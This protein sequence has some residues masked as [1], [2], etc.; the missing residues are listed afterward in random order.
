MHHTD[1]VDRAY[2]ILGLRPGCSSS[3][4]KRRYKHLVKTWHPDRWG[5]DPTGQTE[6]AQRLREINLA[7]QTLTESARA[8]AAHQVTPVPPVPESGS[9]TTPLGR[10]LTK[11]EVEAIVH[12]MT[13]ESPIAAAGQILVWAL[14][15]AIAFIITSGHGRYLSDYWVPPTRKEQTVAAG[16]V[17]L[18]VGVWVRRAWHK[19]R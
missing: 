6:A 11:G 12:A 17:L 8:M 4:I 15:L 14:P 16:L 7:W 2:A 9:Q 13:A 18:A 19:R 3:E 1:P 5:G 10:R